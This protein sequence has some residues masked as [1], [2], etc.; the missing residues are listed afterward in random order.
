MAIEEG[1]PKKNAL[2]LGYT[3]IWPREVLEARDLLEEVKDRLSQ[4]GVY[5]LY[6]DDTPYYVGQAAGRLW[7]RLFS[8]AMRSVG[9][10]HYF[11]NFFSAFAVPEEHLDEAEAMLIAALPTAVNSA[12]PK[13][14]RITLSRKARRGLKRIRLRRAGLLDEQL[15]PPLD[16]DV[17]D[18]SEEDAEG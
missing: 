17:G 8:H 14:T 10:R 7:Q 4:P 1:G 9:K 6:R 13:I 18:E 2:L 5:V 15:P 16:D 3:G 11:W 12:K